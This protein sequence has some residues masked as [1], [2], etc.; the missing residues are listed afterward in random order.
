MIH[1]TGSDDVFPIGCNNDRGLGK[2][3]QNPGPGFT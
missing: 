1:E 3:V 2:M